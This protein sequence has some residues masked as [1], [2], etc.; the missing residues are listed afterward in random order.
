MEDKLPFLNLLS[1]DYDK[2]LV[3]QAHHGMASSTVGTV[4]AFELDLNEFN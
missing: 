1:S 4:L 3:V 2:V